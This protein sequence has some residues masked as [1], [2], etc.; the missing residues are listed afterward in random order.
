MSYWSLYFNRTS[1]V[2]RESISNVLLMKGADAPA[3]A[4]R[5]LFTFN[6]KEDIKQFATGCDADMGGNSTVHLDLVETPET[7]KSI[8]KPATGVFWGEMRLDV[9]PSVHGKIRGGY[10]GFRNKPRPTMFGDL[11]EDVSLHQYLALRVRVG[12]DESTR[13]SY[14]VN[15]QTDSISSHDLWQHR[16][17]FRKANNAWEDIFIPFDSFVRTNAGEITESQITMN[18]EKIKSIG[19]SILGGMSRAAGKYE[20]GIDSIRIV[21]EE[22]TM[23]ALEGKFQHRSVMYADYWI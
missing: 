20:L 18:K 6:S 4:P 14:F 11:T 9:K 13:N 17:Y 21:N 22:D 23:P 10:A 8:G 16:L 19:V 12:G 5:T 1:K 3:R 7:N 15:V 2:L